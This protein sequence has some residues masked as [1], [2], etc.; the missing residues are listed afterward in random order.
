MKYNVRCPKNWIRIADG[1][2]VYVIR[3]YIH[4]N[5]EKKDRK[6]KTSRNKWKR[7]KET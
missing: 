5:H 2:I 7:E 6:K 3:L 1:V 4:N